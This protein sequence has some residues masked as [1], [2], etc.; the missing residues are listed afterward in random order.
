MRDRKSADELTE[1]ELRFRLM[2]KKSIGRDARISA[3]RAGGRSSDP[4][5]APIN[6]ELS[7]QTDKNH[8]SAASEKPPARKKL[9]K[10]LL[11]VETISIIGVV[12]LL[13]MGVNILHNLNAKAEKAFQ[14]PSLTPTALIRAVVLPGGH[15]PPDA[16]G[17]VSFNES[18]IPEHLRSLVDGAQPTPMVSSSSDLPVRIRIPAV[19]VDAPILQGD[20]WETLK[21]G[22]GMSLYSSAPGDKGNLILSGHNDI[23]GQVF[24]DLDQLDTGDEVIVLTE[25][26]SY[27][28]V[29]QAKEVVD[30][31]QVEVMAQTDDASITLISCYPYLVDNKRIILSGKLAD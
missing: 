20:D 8:S 25:K 21:N 31:A 7:W 13:V 12:V 15:T 1:E 2:Q 26:N 22:V 4:D 30:P 10:V 3:F 18:E 19:S 9:D 16:S 29:I 6:P 24:R 27:T 11:V 28:Y 14:L 23:F 17:N 5:D